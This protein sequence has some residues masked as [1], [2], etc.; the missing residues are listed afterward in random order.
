MVVMTESIPDA[1]SALAA[2]TGYGAR[3]DGPLLFDPDDLTDG[4]RAVVAMWEAWGIPWTVHVPLMTGL[5]DG[6]TFFLTMPSGHRTVGGHW[7]NIPALAPVGRAPIADFDPKGVATAYVAFCW[8][9]IA[10]QR[11]SDEP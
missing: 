3:F 1:L 11:W 6:Q 2:T 9:H 10:R 8:D 4:Q 5:W 7:L